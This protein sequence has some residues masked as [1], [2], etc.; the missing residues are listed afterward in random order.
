MVSIECIYGFNCWRFIYVKVNVIVVDVV[1]CKVWYFYG[2]F[3]FF[4]LFV[5]DYDY[6][7][8]VENGGGKLQLDV[9]IK[10]LIGL[11]VNLMK[12]YLIKGNLFLVSLIGYLVEVCF[13]CF[14]EYE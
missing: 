12:L 2:F 3:W 1:V 13:Q 11:K 14:D 5:G 9:S 10:V 7:L 4:F 6:I 8:I